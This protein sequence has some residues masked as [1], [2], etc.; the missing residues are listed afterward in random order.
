V[1]CL[2]SCEVTERSTIIVC[3]KHQFFRLVRKIAKRQLAL[4]CLSVCLRPSAL[5]SSPTGRILIKF[6]V[7]TI[8]GKPAGK[9]QVLLNKTG[10]KG[11]LHEDQ[12]TCFIISHLFLL[13][14]RKCI[15]NQNKYFM[16]SNIFF[17]SRTVCEIIWKKHSRAG[18]ATGDNRRMRNAHT[19][20][21]Q[22]SLLFHCI[23][24]YTDA[25]QRYVDTYIAYLFY[26]V[27][28]C[29]RH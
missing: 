28:F 29:T 26:R 6:D 21:L 13:R 1:T 10:I 5:N 25:P 22:Y 16:F 27:G 23:C 17:E 3:S 7:F 9:N 14:R 15:V 12:C 24:G 19:Q 8:F 2:G 20:V 11:T 18:Q 4:S